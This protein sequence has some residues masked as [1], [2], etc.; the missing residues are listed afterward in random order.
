MAIPNMINAL[1]D[2]NKIEAEGAF[3]EVI[4]QKVG[5]ALDLKRV[6]IANTLVKHHVPQD[7]DAG[8]EV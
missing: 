6:E 2:D 5:D 4:A 3:K 1:I 7:A 8:E